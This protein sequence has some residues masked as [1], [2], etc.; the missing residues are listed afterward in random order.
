MR[1]RV[2]VRHF[3]LLLMCV[4]ARGRTR[5]RAC[6]RVLLY[7]SSFYIIFFQYG[8]YASIF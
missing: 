6:V 2:S 5:A 3:F 7:F 1:G 4:R 8:I